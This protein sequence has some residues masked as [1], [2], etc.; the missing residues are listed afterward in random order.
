MSSELT[1]PNPSDDEL[2][3][4]PT[5]RLLELLSELN[6]DVLAKLHTVARV[7]RVLIDKG[8]KLTSQQVP[9]L[10]LIK[11]VA[12]GITLPEVVTRFIGR[13]S[14]IPLIGKL[15][16]DEQKRLAEGGRVP[17][18][19]HDGKGGTTVLM[20]DPM[21][22][23]KQQVEQ[24]FATADCETR[25]RSEQEQILLLHS[26]RTKEK[27]KRPD[28]VEDWKLDHELKKARNGSKWHTLETLEAVVAAL[29]QA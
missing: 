6:A 4:L 11:P 27:A 17:L 9:L 22:M 16:H 25:V 26:Q 8:V 5:E 7:V 2:A 14:L 20:A 18:S 24:V 12:N 10:Y 19:V 15:P 13:S 3:A 21:E 23:T 29:R 1:S 28:K